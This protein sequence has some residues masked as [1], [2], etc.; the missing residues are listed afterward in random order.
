MITRQPN[1]MIDQNE[2]LVE[3]EYVDQEKRTVRINLV[4]LRTG[5]IR[6][7]QMSFDELG[8]RAFQYEIATWKGTYAEVPMIPYKETNHG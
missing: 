8:K 1:L 6:Q 5:E 2:V 3:L 4:F 7:K